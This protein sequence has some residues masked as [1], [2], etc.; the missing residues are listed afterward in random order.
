MTCFGNETFGPVVALYRFHDEADAVERANRGVRPQRLD[1]QPGGSR[2][3]ALA[4]K[5]KCGT[6]NINE[7]Y[8]SSFGSLAAPMGGMRESGIGSRQGPEGILRY[9]EAQTVATQRGVR[10][11][12]SFGLSQEQYAKAMTLSLRV[13]NKLGRA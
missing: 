7:G 3:R 1:L 8:A 13:L 6:V 12:P 10:I 2:A 11:G 4:R 5:V 9:V